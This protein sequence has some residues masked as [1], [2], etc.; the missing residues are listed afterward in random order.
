MFKEWARARRETTNEFSLVVL[1]CK[2][3][4]RS[5]RTIVRALIWHDVLPRLEFIFA[6]LPS[7]QID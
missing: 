1:D 5:G 7:P 4:K 3:H 6:G 2:S